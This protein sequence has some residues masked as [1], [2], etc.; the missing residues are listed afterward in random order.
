MARVRRT[1]R[2]F[3]LIHIHIVGGDL[4]I[5]KN[6]H[7]I[8]LNDWV[9]RGWKSCGNSDDFIAGFKCLVA[10]LRRSQAG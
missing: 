2:S 10:K 5:H 6:R 8:I 7:K 4:N 3:E 1:E 9:D